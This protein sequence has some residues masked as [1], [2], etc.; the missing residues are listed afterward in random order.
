MVKECR[1]EE[2]SGGGG[3]EWWGRRVVGEGHL[4]LLQL[5]HDHGHLTQQEGVLLFLDL[6]AIVLRKEPSLHVVLL[7]EGVGDTDRQRE[8]QRDRQT[9]R[10]TDRERE[11]EREIEHS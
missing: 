11:R 5:G 10:P 4:E 2:E 8:R 3:G 1:G 7:C 6:I 9:D